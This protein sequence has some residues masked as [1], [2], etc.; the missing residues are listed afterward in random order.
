MHLFTFENYLFH[1]HIAIQSWNRSFVSGN[2]LD[3]G[4]EHNVNSQTKF[5]T[6]TYKALHTLD[7]FISCLII[8][9][10]T[11]FNC[12]LQYIYICKGNWKIS[13]MILC[14]SMTKRTKWLVRP[15]KTHIS[16]GTRPWLI[17]G[18]LATN[19]AHSEDWSDWVDAQTDLSLHWAHRSL[20]WFCHAATQVQFTNL[21]SKY[22]GKCEC[23]IDLKLYEL[24]HKNQIGSYC[25]LYKTPAK[26]KRSNQERNKTVIIKASHNEHSKF[27]SPDWFMID[28]LTD[29]LIDWLVGWLVDWLIDCI[30]KKLNTG[31]RTGI[32]Q[33]LLHA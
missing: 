8:F 24:Q 31:T 20:C 4:F 32:S 5:R 15:A 10:S 23:D 9:S 7:I 18:S 1:R 14:R 19:L 16:L 28:W 6:G 2:Q 30:V 33:F 11:N 29:W 25:R 22:Q 13:S 26:W 17:M 27:P 21:R 12:N 3:G